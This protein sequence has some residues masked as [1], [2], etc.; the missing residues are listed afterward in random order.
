MD[1]QT[2]RYRWRTG[3]WPRV[4]LREGVPVG[5]MDTVEMAALVVRALNEF[6]RQRDTATKE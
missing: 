5:V 1:E 3:A 2:R 6:D 4:I